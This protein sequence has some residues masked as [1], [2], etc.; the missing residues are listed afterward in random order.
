MFSQNGFSEENIPI[1]LNPYDI[2]K[3]FVEDIISRKI[4]G[5]CDSSVLAANIMG[6]IITPLILIKSGKI[7]RNALDFSDEIIHNI[8][9]VLM[10]I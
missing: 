4:I 3:V 7:R 10:N 2:I 6:I 5:R 1:D 9:S 8:Y